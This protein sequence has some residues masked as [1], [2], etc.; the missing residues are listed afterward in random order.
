M[1]RFFVCSDRF[2]TQ[3]SAICKNGTGGQSS[4]CK[5]VGLFCSEIYENT[6]VMAPLKTRGRALQ[7]CQEQGAVAVASLR[8]K[9][10]TMGN[11]AARQVLEA[12]RNHNCEK[13]CTDDVGKNTMDCSGVNT[14]PA[15]RVVPTG[16]EKRSIFY[17]AP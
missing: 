13:L 2:L 3:C 15:R 17:V 1:R 12:Q 10:N 5:R 14:P 9:L 11:P 8:Y 4:L 6:V 7:L 16:C